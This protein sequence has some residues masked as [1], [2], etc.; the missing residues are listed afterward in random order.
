M[1]PD[2]DYAPSRGSFLRPVPPPSQEP[3][4][5]P[6]KTVEV[7]CQWLP[8]IRGALMQLLLQATWVSTDADLSL[9]QGRVWNLIDLFAECDSAFLPIAC[10]YPF[11]GGDQGGWVV[12]HRTDSNG[13]SGDAAQW[14][15]TAFESCRINPPGYQQLG[16]NKCLGQR[17]DAVTLVVTTASPFSY[18]VYAYPACLPTP[19]TP[20]LVCAGGSS[21]GVD[22]RVTCAA[23]I[24]C[25]MLL[26]ILT[27]SP[28]DGSINV[29][30]LLTEVDLILEN[31]SGACP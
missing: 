7:N 3:G 9:T 27:N 2:A 5:S 14:T 20:T 24:D 4:A 29:P 26:I 25:G 18:E 30:I 19:G 22:V 31:S 8:Y 23:G 12:G 21:D 15:G 16:V 17:L 6:T 13:C 1:W 28:A 11:E 10:P